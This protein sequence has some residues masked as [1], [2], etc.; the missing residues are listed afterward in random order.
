MIHQFI[1]YTNCVYCTAEDGVD[2]TAPEKMMHKV[3]DSHQGTCMSEVD[4]NENERCVRHMDTVG[5]S[6]AD[7]CTLVCADESTNNP[8]SSHVH[9]PVNMHDEMYTCPMNGHSELSDT[10]LD[11]DAYH[12]DATCKSQYTNTDL[13][14]SFCGTDSDLSQSQRMQLTNTQKVKIFAMELDMMKVPVCAPDSENSSF[15]SLT[16]SMSPA[17]FM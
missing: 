14:D 4:H 2:K 5:A 17:V 12:K 6:I 3:S 7:D 11:T 10:H 1:H 9:C 13:F 8:E 15:N 16:G